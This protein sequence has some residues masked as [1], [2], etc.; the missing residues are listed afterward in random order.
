MR[1]HPVALVLPTLLTCSALG[2]LPAAMVSAAHAESVTVADPGG[3]VPPMLA[4]ESARFSNRKKRVKVVVSAPEFS[5][6][7]VS[8]ARLEVLV[9]KQKGNPGYRYHYQLSWDR[10]SGGM[11]LYESRAGTD[12]SLRIKC[13]GKR[14]H[15]DEAAGRITM[16]LPTR[17]LNGGA[18]V[19]MGYQHGSTQTQYGW[20]AVPSVDD[21]VDDYGL[22]QLPTFTRW[23]RRG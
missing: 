4:I 12:G 5:L 2:V 17:C 18:K 1:P 3:N 6:Q 21:A 19:Q 14:F 13:R 10:D 7:W 9:G 11:T 8:W 23:L 16:S 22:G 15:S 20:D